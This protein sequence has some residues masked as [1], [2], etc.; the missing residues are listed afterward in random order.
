MRSRIPSIPSR[1]ETGLL[2]LLVWLGG[3]TASAPAPGKAEAS[4]LET[5]GQYVVEYAGRRSPEFGFADWPTTRADGK[6]VA[7]WAVKE[8]H[9]G[10]LNDPANSFLA[11]CEVR[12]DALEIRQRLAP[13]CKVWPVFSEKG[14]LL[15]YR[16][17]YLNPE[18]TGEYAGVGT[19]MYGP[20]KMVD[21][22][23]VFSDDGSKAAYAVEDEEGWRLLLVTTGRVS[24]PY[25]HIS[26][27]RFDELSDTIRF[28]TG[29][30]RQ[31]QMTWQ[32]NE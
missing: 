26:D 5:G 13:G 18:R 25:E 31:T 6:Y 21:I 7:F 16:A 8:N 20:W 4:V 1:F 22:W 23:P 9:E 12:P 32:F 11:V 2:A 29:R 3:C 30:D 14:E 24:P 19:T 28:R 15:V 17:V 10:A 27:V